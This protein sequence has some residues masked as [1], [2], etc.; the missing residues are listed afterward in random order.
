MMKK[1]ILFTILFILTGITSYAEQPGD[2]DKQKE[3]LVNLEIVSADNINNKFSNDMF[4]EGLE[5]IVT[6]K[7]G[8]SPEL[9]ARSKGLIGENED[10]NGS[11]SVTFEKAVRYMIYALGYDVMYGSES[12]YLDVARTAGLLDGVEYIAQ[13]TLTNS[14]GIKILMNFT[15]AKPL[16]TD[17]GSYDRKISDKPHLKSSEKYTKSEV[18]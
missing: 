5:N 18:L 4:I 6:D 11:G 2:L 14:D 17:I 10:Y 16:L 8:M 12:Q 3:I 9:F 15:E 7:V 13:K 1:F